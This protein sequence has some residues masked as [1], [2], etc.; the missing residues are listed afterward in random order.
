V[1]TRHLFVAMAVFVAG[2][3]GFAVVG[4]RSEGGPT[5]RAPVAGP[6]SPSPSAPPPAY[7]VKHLLSPPRDYLGVALD[8]AP[9]DMSRVDKWVERVG[10]RP[11]MIT[12]YESFEDEFAAAEVRTV[13]SYG[14]LPI[15]RWE[16]FTVKL[17]DIAAG[18]QD[19]YVTD[20]ATAVRRL[21][22][23]I[24]LTVAHEMNGHWYPWGTKGNKA[25]DFVAAWK[26]IHGIFTQVGATNVIWTWTPNVV[27]PVRSV[28][29]QPYWPGEEFVDWVG[30]DGYFTHAGDQ[31]YDRLFGPTMR[32]IRK[33]TKLPFLIVETGSEPGS[34]RT[35]AVEDLFTNVAEARD[36]IGFV[37][38]NQ[39]GSGDWRLDFDD[40]ALAEYRQQAG[41]LGFGFPVR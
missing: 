11:N 22:L 9:Q 18:K 19:P 34:M 17:A 23:P 10:Q 14:A 33:F 39:K 38:F 24:A 3:F 35:R 21:N 25:A 27:N 29:L 26:R 28:A 36:V 1:K 6:A 12:I 5:D 20:F 40:D 32:Q 4:P 13:Y 30:I 16:P 37:Y 15:V 31:T 8:G 41:S 2:V 7:D